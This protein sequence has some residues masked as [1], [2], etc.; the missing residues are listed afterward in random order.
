[1]KGLYLHI[2]F[3]Q[4][5][6]RFCDFAAYPGLKAEIPRYLSALE[7]EIRS[8]GGGPLETLFVGGGTPTALE[9][10]QLSGLLGAVR[11]VFEIVPGFEGTVECNPESAT[12]ER[13]EA[14]REG[15]IN[16]L[17]FGLQAAQ[18]R[19]LRALGR[20]HDFAAFEKAWRLA[21]SIGFGNL[22][23]DLM[24]GLPGQT[25]AEWDETLDR[26]LALAPE[27][28]SA[29][30]LAVEERTAFGRSGVATDG[31]FQAELYERAAERLESAGF[32]HYEISNFARPGREC[33]HNLRY[34]RNQDC[35][36]AGVS[37]ASY[38]GGVRRT[39]SAKVANY[40]ETVEQGRPAWIEE[41][42]LSEPERVGEDLMLALRLKE[43]APVGPRARE[44]YGPVLAKYEAL[45]FLKLSEGRAR[46]NLRGWLLS[47]RLF[48]EL[49]S[50][51]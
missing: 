45:G 16:R 3:C 27:H 38:V 11:G 31:D 46:P 6:C 35:L 40:I 23:A 5:K 24:Y 26:V 41:V 30:A 21:R 20:L 19:H 15:G 32:V 9:A 28:V 25:P 8:L 2:P 51:A 50:P 47:N 48:E 18:D 36:G 49:L 12:A 1:M 34:W 14:L 29:Y 22:N 37:A 44:L 33:R 7:R 17:S 10:A 39:N 13:L 43:G 42:V 4:V